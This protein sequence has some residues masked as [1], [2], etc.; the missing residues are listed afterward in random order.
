MLDWTFFSIMLLYGDINYINFMVFGN[1]DYTD[2]WLGYRPDMD[3]PF[4]FS[5]SPDRS[6]SYC[7]K[8]FCDF[9]EEKVFG[10]LCLDEVWRKVCIYSV[11]GVDFETWRVSNIPALGWMSLD[12]R[13][14]SDIDGFYNE[15][16]KIITKNLSF[17]PDHDMKTLDKILNGGFGVH[18]YGQP[19]YI[20]WFHFN[21][22][23]LA[24]GDEVVNDLISTI[25]TNN[26]VNRR[27]LRISE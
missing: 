16:Y 27:E 5:L 23:R 13:R 10:D 7:F 12:G 18:I 25:L 1:P 21:D 22:S 26:A 8:H 15:I 14:F 20:D 9:E 24:L 6:R 17:T 2:C 3:E 19:L 4:W 11:N